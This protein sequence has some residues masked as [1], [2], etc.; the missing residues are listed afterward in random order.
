[1]PT[2]LRPGFSASP[3]AH[4]A[5]TMALR[6]PILENCSGPVAG[7]IQMAR[8]SSSGCRALRLTPT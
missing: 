3:K 8:M 5:M 1:M 4:T 6:V 2:V 7:A